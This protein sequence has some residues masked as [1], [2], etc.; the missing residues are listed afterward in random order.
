MTK[1]LREDFFQL[2]GGQLIGDGPRLR[3]INPST[4]LVAAS[5][6]DATR[7]QLDSAV[8]AATLAAV[9]WAGT[10]YDDRGAVVRRIADAL[11]ENQDELGDL[12]TLEMGRP[13]A[14]SRAEVVR[15]A[16]TMDALTSIEIADE[17]LEDSPQRYAV[18]TY[19]PLGV[20]GVI[21]PWN[22]PIN[23]AMGPLASAL[24]TGNTVVLKPSPFT[25]LS[26]LKLGEL[27]K[28]VVPA[29]V[30]NILAGGDELGAWI[31]SHPGIRKITFTGSVA[32]G[33]KVMAS[34]AVNLK[35]LTLE[36]GGNDAAIVLADV[37]PVEVAAK[38]AFA[39]FVNT[40]QVCMA[41]KRIYAHDAV[42][43]DLTAA[44][45]AQASALVV[46][47]AARPEVDLG[48]I[49]N[50]PQYER[51]SGIIE[52]THESGGRFL[53]GGSRPSG[54]GYF[55]EPAVVVEAREDSRLVREEQFGPVVPVL[56]YSDIDDAIE[57]ANATNYGLCASVW[58]RDIEEAGRIARRLEVG[59]VWVN[60][61]RA[62]SP[63][64][65]FGGAKESGVGRVYSALGLKSYLEPR[66]VN[67]LKD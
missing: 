23:L 67:I 42:Y 22:A 13:A 57:R 16:D 3:V 10:G 35:R 19:F 44:L 14:Q 31:T 62:T 56:R 2:I 38:L 64:M 34:A 17:M 9:S 27:I 65:P 39:S 53:A 54:E 49:Q 28:D 25:P 30:V 11:R 15:S 61:H 41:V 59:T 45:A 32:T 46:G 24:Y 20:V 12:L 33:K 7:G 52:D 66:V 36:L 47:D 37:D 18:L 4:G 29:G 60:Q 8:E 21:T 58:T 63:H 1:Q 50:L 43:D 55:V 51:V 26:T 40:G 6:P 48:P 5:C